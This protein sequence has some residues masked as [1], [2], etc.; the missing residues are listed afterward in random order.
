LPWITIR[1]FRR[2][3]VAIPRA[4]RAFRNPTPL[5]VMG[6]S[7]FLP[8]FTMA[9]TQTATTTT[10]S[11]SG[12]AGNYTLTGTISASSGNAAAALSGTVSFVDTTD[13]SAVLATANLV[14]SSSSSLSWKPFTTTVAVKQ[15]QGI[16]VA[17]FNGDG[18]PDLAVAALAPSSNIGVI[19][20]FTGKGDGTLSTPTLYPLNSIP[21]GIVVGSFGGGHGNSDLAVIDSTA[22]GSVNF[23]LNDGQGFFTPGSSVTVPNTAGAIAVGPNNAYLAVT[24]GS[25]SGGVAILTLSAQGV[26]SLTSTVS[27]DAYPAGIV[28][29]SHGIAVS[30]CAPAPAAGEVT[31]LTPSGSSFQVAKNYTVGNCAISIAAGS[32]R[33]TGTDLMVANNRDN[34]A[35][36][37]LD[38]GTGNYAVETPFAVGIAP[39]GLVIYDFNKDG[40]ADFAVAS[41]TGNSVWIYTGKGDGTFNAPAVVSVGSGP[42]AV[43]AASFAT[44]NTV[45]L[46]V[47]NTMGGTVTNLVSQVGPVST[48]TANKIAVPGTGSH[49]VVAQYSGDANYSASQSTGVALTAQLVVTSLAVSANPASAAAGQQVALSATLSPYNA[50][51]VSTNGESVTFSSGGASLGTAPLSSGVA[52][53]NLAT[54]VAGSH[55]VTASYAGDANF[56]AGTAP[57]VTVIVSGAAA[58]IATV[59]PSGL[60]F[61]SQS[62]G[63]TSSPQNITLTNSGHAA[64]TI[65]SIAATGPFKQTNTCGS[66]V[67]VTSS[68]TIAVSFAPTAG[69]AATGSLAITDNASGSPQT[70]TLTGTGATVGVSSGSPPLAV[71][72]P[73]G[74]ATAAIQLSSV[75]GFSGSVNLTC[76]VAFQGSGT[77]ANPPACSLNPTQVQVSGTSNATS[78]L[79]VTTT[80]ATVAAIHPFRDA[81][82]A[83]G[84]LFLVVAIPRKRRGTLLL[85][86]LLIAVCGGFAGC[87][88]KTPSSTSNQTGTTTGSYIV[89]VTATSGNTTAT[90]PVPLTVN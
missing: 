21:T 78:T 70:V 80:A 43:A 48:A 9:H 85:V 76:T 54:L 7:I 49:L 86:L 35:Q 37:L 58:P 55:S 46:A 63:T 66:S 40:K 81:G 13:A 51:G 68:C 3:I 79:T 31:T 39:Y 36:A 25:T 69:G 18:I 75:S 82:L 87:G 2:N 42:Q 50:N 6:A 56:A 44:G 24:V 17:D 67:A 57:A 5:L 60:T 14:A 89:T 33:A 59:S 19:A 16:A 38:D 4:A 47:T 72:A 73:G 22:S 10:L 30:H 53:L 62:A 65:T 8:A 20:L 84:G 27:V 45:D 12:A 26:W 11:S 71:T 32:F 52:T 23:F 28:T 77:A 64:L 88:G 61:A 90:T 41:Q 1:P 29:T 34:R 74:S 15:P 83:L